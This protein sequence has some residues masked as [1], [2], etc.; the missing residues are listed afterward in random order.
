M[1]TADEMAPS[2]RIRLGRLGGALFIIGS[3]AAAPAA[4]FLEPAPDAAEYLIAVAAVL[5]GAALMAAPWGRLP[6]RALYGVSILATGYVV[7]GASLYSDDFAFYQVLIAVYTAYVVR[8]RSDFLWL[9]VFF[10]VATVAPLFYV[11]EDINDLAHHVLV[12]L[13]VMIISAAVVRYLR[14]AL[15]RRE[16]QYRRFAVEAVT[17]AERIRGGPAPEQEATA[18]NVEERL[19]ELASKTRD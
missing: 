14:N 9:M 11:D 15:A 16:L 18:E 3:L 10:T 12:T 6:D 4:A 17:L 2:E 5:V 8:E 19:A 13:P 7:L 1:A